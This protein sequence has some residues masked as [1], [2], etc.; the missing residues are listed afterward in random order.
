MKGA[1][2][3][4]TFK[5]WYNCA[6]EQCQNCKHK[7]FELLGVLYCRSGGKQKVSVLTQ[8]DHCAAQD[9]IYKK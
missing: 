3:L 9:E 5:G 4:R 6:Y 8:Q 2:Y 7:R 1:D